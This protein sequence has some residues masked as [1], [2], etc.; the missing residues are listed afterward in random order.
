MPSWLVIPS[1]IIARWA[2]LRAR[3]SHPN[4]LLAKQKAGAVPALSDK[5]RGIST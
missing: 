5:R 1:L 2:G 4:R 3:T